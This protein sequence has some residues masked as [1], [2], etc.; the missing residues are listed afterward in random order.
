M[1]NDSN[2]KIMEI[3]D[4]LN[5]KESVF[6]IH[7]PICGKREGHLYIHRY[8]ERHGGI[9]LWCSCCHSFSHLSGIIPDWV[10]NMPNI[11][12]SRLEAT[13]EYLDERKTAVD[14]WVNTLLKRKD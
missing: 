1:W 3:M 10:E 5:S 11:E 9:W 13:P 4:G 2:D 6:P 8:D 7:C 12:N 14:N